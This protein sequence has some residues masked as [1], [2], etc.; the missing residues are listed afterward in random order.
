MNRREA[1][2]EACFRVAMVAENALENGWLHEH[3]PD[4]DDERAVAEGVQEVVAELI[5]RGWRK[6]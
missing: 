5:R 2:R 3:Y 6:P 4:E 1:K